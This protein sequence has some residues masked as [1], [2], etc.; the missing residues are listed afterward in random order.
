MLPG[1]GCVGDGQWTASFDATAHVTFT[2]IFGMRG[3]ALHAGIDLAAAEGTPLL[4]ASGGTVEAVSTVDNGPRGLY[5]SITHDEETVSQYFHM[6]EVL[7][8]PGDILSG[9]QLIGKVG[10]TGRSY[11]AHLHLEILIGGDPVDPLAF[12]QA[13]GVNY[14]ELATIGDT[15]VATTCRK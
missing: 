11:G 10:N 5:V 8:K 3:A 7:V 13:R 2:D 1:T 4:A 9:G 15:K 14:C 12:L 6:S